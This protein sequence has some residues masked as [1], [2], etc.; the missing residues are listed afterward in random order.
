M[1]VRFAKAAMLPIAAIQFFLIIFGLPLIS[2][3]SN[4]SDI[5]QVLGPQLSPEAN[6]SFPGSAEFTV[7]GSRWTQGVVNPGYFASVEVANEKD[8]ELAVSALMC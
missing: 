7:A 4:A 6:I 5:L 1:N 3:Q 8:V 2:A